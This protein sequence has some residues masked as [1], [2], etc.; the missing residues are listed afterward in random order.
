[1][2]TAPAL[3]TW[4][5]S[6]IVLVDQTAPASIHSRNTF[7]SAADKGGRSSGISSAS[8]FFQSKLSAALPGTMA[9]PFFPP[10]SADSFR[11]KSSRPFC[12]AGP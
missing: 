2:A 12:F 10:A 11:D 3:E 8:T 5:N 1:V 4:A 7:F 6:A 9:L